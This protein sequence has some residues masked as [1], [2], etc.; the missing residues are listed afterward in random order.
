MGQNSVE[1]REKLYHDPGGVDNRGSRCLSLGHIFLI[2]RC[3]G[4]AREG[5][6]G[7]SGWRWRRMINSRGWGLGVRD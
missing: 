2:D 1:D 5:G 4:E 7:R 3:E 6:R